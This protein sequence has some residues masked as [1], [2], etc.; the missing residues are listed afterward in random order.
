MKKMKYTFLLVA[1]LCTAGILR[2]QEYKIPVENTKDAKL[3]LDDFTGELPIEGYSGNEIIIT[4]GH[5]FEQNDRAKGLKPIYAAGTDNTGV[6]VAME[7]N[8]NKVT[9][10][11]LLSIT[12]S[13]EYKIRVPENM[14]LEIT[15]DCPKGG[16]TIISNIKNEVEFKGCHDISLKNVTGPLVISTIS[17]NV[18]VVFTEVAKDKPISISSVSGEVDVTLP[19]K[20][21]FSVEMGTVSGNMYSDFEFPTN[22]DMKRIGGGKLRADFNGGGTAV[23]LNVV[24]GN[25]YLRKS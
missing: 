22:N 6:G 24:S 3:I 16:E 23:R 9:L 17:G 8:G 11:C 19:A 7:K 12:Q 18:N 20:T 14:A 4:T 10:R 25:I 21:P 13:A 2:A 15:R 5:H 1:S